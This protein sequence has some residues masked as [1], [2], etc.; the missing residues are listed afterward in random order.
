[1]TVMRMD[2][3]QL[4]RVKKFFKHNE[5]EL[6]SQT[7]FRHDQRWWIR[8]NIDV[9]PRHWLEEVCDGFAQ[10]EPS[11][12][13]GLHPIRRLFSIKNVR[14]ARRRRRTHLAWPVAKLSACVPR[15]LLYPSYKVDVVLYAIYFTLSSSPPILFINNLV[16]TW[17]FVKLISLKY[18]DNFPH[19][20][21]LII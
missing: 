1:M 3:S 19:T 8:L 11:M 6:T 5:L 16:S 20:V 7:K 21:L 10:V 13:R 18:G 12:R 2:E 15:P 9:C 17:F 14:L 4:K